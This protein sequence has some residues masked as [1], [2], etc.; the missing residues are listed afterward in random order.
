MV[1]WG[2]GDGS[3][4][5]LASR[6]SLDPRHAAPAAAQE[7][8]RQK[9]TPGSTATQAPAAAASGPR[10][11][12]P[13][14]S[15]LLVEDNADN[16]EVMARVLGRRGL[17]VVV[18][19]NG[20]RALERVADDRFDI[21]MMDCQMPEMDGFAATRAIRQMGGACS[22]VPVVALTAYG[23]TGTQRYFDAG[24]DDLVAKPY[25]IQEI[26][27]ALYRWLVL[28]RDDGAEAGESTGS[29]VTPA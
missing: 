24:F 9:Q 20:R 11:F 6:G 25:T 18:A 14:T 16:R 2:F 21:I 3:T 27:E 5:S 22:L 1:W 17:R 19:E 8:G 12:R 13:G 23:V 10:Q 26:D 7:S 4:L 29:R 28:A 15:V